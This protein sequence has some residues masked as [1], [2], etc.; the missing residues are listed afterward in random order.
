MK[1]GNTNPKIKYMKNVN[2]LLLVFLV[3]FQSCKKDNAKTEYAAEGQVSFVLNNETVFEGEDIGDT[4]NGQL[5]KAQQKP[6]LVYQQV[7]QEK[8]YDKDMVSEITVEE[9][10]PSN[11]N[12]L[13]RDGRSLQAS[14]GNMAVIPEYPDKYN[15]G[16]SYPLTVGVKYRVLI[17]DQS[18]NFVEQIDGTAGTLPPKTT[19][20]SQGKT[21]TWFAYSYYTSDALPA[22]PTA[23]LSN[24]TFPV[25][26]ED[27]LYATGNFTTPTGSGITNIDVPIT[28]K[29]TMA[30]VEY[31]F[32]MTSF[33]GRADNSYGKFVDYTLAEADRP[34]IKADA[35][36]LSKGTFNLKSG[37]FTGKT[38]ISTP[39]Y[40]V[41]KG[42][43]V[44]GNPNYPSADYRGFFFTVPGAINDY[45]NAFKI[46]ASPWVELDRPSTPQKF[47]KT[48]SHKVRV[49]AG[50][51]TRI[52]VMPFDA[53]I[54]L[55]PFDNTGA[56]RWARGDAYYDESQPFRPPYESNTRFQHR[57][58]E[59]TSVFYGST[60]QLNGATGGSTYGASPVM[61]G[62]TYY[63]QTSS[64]PINI[65][66]Q[67]VGSPCEKFA[68]SGGAAINKW[69]MPKMPDA[70]ILAKFINDNATNNTFVTHTFNTTTKSLLLTLNLN[71]NSSN[72]WTQRISFEM[73]G[74]GSYN[75][76]SG[77]Y[78][79]FN[80]TEGST[81]YTHPIVTSA[82]QKG[83]AYI[84]IVNA[85]VK[86]GFAYLQLSI[87]SQ[88]P[89]RY[90]AQ[91]Y[92]V[93]LGGPFDGV[94]PAPSNISS[95]DGMTIRCIRVAA[96]Y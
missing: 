50:K 6:T 15:S 11:S 83:S 21:Y 46:T 9:V 72:E 44:V 8:I 41:A 49:G 5:A 35:N 17:Y 78:T 86:D 48:Y 43:Y 18:S 54:Q 81:N 38:I 90:K 42:N 55:P 95:K 20:L 16:V 93:G 67:V 66:P 53:A 29:H 13:K 64:V 23:Q 61:Y 59:P 77:T 56:R 94:L 47:L 69:T 89:T 73:K 62:S 58:N 87:D 7:A 57:N 4:G 26:N 51:A 27:F 52:T 71:G 45:I 22:I 1:I 74:M 24:P 37:T 14:N 31:Q 30:M 36:Q 76:S 28:F 32:N 2:I 82:Q 92:Q 75:S 19:K 60:F 39:V 65:D 63:T 34:Y 10:G 40:A 85:D 70:K 84:W 91:I 25:E 33:Q 68:P 3:V 80:F 88:A 12:S 79:L 96:S